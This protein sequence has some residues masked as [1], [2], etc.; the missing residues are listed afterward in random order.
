ME[1]Y[2][3]GRWKSGG[4]E[5]RILQPTVT[6]GSNYGLDSRWYPENVQHYTHYTLY[7]QSLKKRSV[8]NIT[9]AKR[10]VR[11]LTQLYTYCT[12]INAE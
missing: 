11:H 5:W 6:T 12:W 4:K 10:P 3:T 2:E 1:A 8:Q 9:F 7:V